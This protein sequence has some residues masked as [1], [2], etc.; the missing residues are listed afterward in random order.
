MDR[1]NR[2]NM[3][4]AIGIGT[5]I[6]FIALILVAAIAAAVIIKTAE[7]LEEKA[8]VAGEDAQDLVRNTPMIIL[9]EGTVNSNSINSVD[10]YIDLYGSE[11]VD[12]NDVVL[13]VV[14]VPLSGNGVSV[15][16]MFNSGAPTTAD[17]DNYGVTEVNDPLNQYDPTATPARFIL[18]ERT[19]LKLTINLNSALVNLPPNSSLEIWTHVTTSGHIRYD[20]FSTPSAYPNGGVIPLEG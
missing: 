6:I 9:A 11:G 14:A 1:I 2:M 17:V 4:A 20:S 13:H 12:M 3:K 16:L 15:D 19:L 8:E 10:L 7:Q 5:L 18:G